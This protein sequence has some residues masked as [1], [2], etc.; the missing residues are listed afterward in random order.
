MKHI[1]YTKSLFPI[2]FDYLSYLVYLSPK[3]DYNKENYLKILVSFI[4]SLY[5]ANLIVSFFP[6]L[7]IDISKAVNFFGL[8][9][10]LIL[11]LF[12]FSS[13]Y[14]AIMYLL[15]R[16]ISK[17][18]IYFLQIVKM[19]SIM[20]LTLCIL[21]TINIHLMANQYVGKDMTYYYIL[22]IFIILLNFYVFHKYI[23][24]TIY[25]LVIN[26]YKFIKSTIIILTLIALPNII[27]HTIPFFKTQ[28]FDAI[29]KNDLCTQFSHLKFNII[30]SKKDSLESEINVFINECENKF[31]LQN[32][33]QIL[34][35][36]KA[37]SKN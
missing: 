16:D 36:V 29:N 19:F 14:C 35:K 6:N 7:L 32:K 3:I 20:H 31:T 22:F 5:F 10:V 1:S 26:K 27:Y 2:D 11:N 17:L 18:H 21:L 24:L 23:G 25:N 33:S 8:I 30:E 9:K 4:T 28:T 37:S 12:L 13:I 15:I 34:L